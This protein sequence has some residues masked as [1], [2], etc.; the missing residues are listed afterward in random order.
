MGKIVKYCSS[1]DEGFAEKFG[2]C[3]D[4]GAQLQAFEMNPLTGEAI[5]EPGM[6]EVP[7]A[8]QEQAAE[9]AEPEVFEETLETDGTF[10]VESES[11][12][13]H[14]SDEIEE[15]I[16]PQDTFVEVP[17]GA[18][19]ATAVS[20]FA[21]VPYRAADTSVTDGGRY[22]PNEDFKVTIV[23]EKNTKQRNELLLGTLALMVTFFCTLLV[24]G[25]F[26]QDLNVGAIGDESSL[27]YVGEVVDTPM[28]E[29]K[30]KVEKK[31][32]TGGGG[33][34]G[35]EEQDPASKGVNAA[36]MKDPDVAPSAHM[37]RLT[38]PTLTQ[39][40]GVQGPDQPN[41]DSTQRYGINNS[42]FDGI[43]DGP[44][45]GG[46]IG[47]GRGGGIGSGNGSG[48]G[49][50]S[51][52][53]MGSGTGGGIGDGNGP[54][55]GPP[56]PPSR[57]AVTEKVKILFKPKAPYT[58]EARQNNVQGSVTLKVVFLASGQIGS[59]T[60]LTRLPYGLTENAIAAARQIK[61][62][63]AKR[64]G[65]PYTTSVTFQYGFNIY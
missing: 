31:N 12:N 37:D 55:G 39:R 5:A 65:V 43:S 33:G 38:N 54:G 28:E 17:A 1:C 59:I 20:T 11:T 45:S 41:V 3:P 50:G 30:I 29:E 7:S 58:D 63:P 47:T 32:D 24:Y 15:T 62:E 14:H 60:P 53:G 64:D 49:S 9:M 42:R 51:G 16:E 46:G 21:G 19:A 26:A 2:F 6:P 52:G 56:P 44:G 35:N 36:M 8:V 48:L 10:P 61:F 40:V 13:G 23:E 25:L 34:G 27:A 57:P 4:C 22:V 18:T